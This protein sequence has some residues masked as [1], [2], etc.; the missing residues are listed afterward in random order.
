MGMRRVVGPREDPLCSLLDTRCSQLSGRCR[1]LGAVLSEG[2]G[3]GMISG[4]YRAG[5]AL[6]L[7]LIGSSAGAGE[8]TKGVIGF[9][10]GRLDARGLQGQPSGLRA[11]DY[12][13]CVPAEESAR[14]E[15]AA[16]DP[17]ARFMP[18]SPGRIGC[19]AGETLV[20][21]STHQPGFRAILEAL[22]ALPYVSRIIE[23]HFE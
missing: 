17:S 12:E 10:L 14:A 2:R 9:D 15:V 5:A 21:G 1:T 20:L 7:I 13:Y 11:L 23:A 18:G 3:A 4:T 6:A 22:A 19:G 16:I 8:P